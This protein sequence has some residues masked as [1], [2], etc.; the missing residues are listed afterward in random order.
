MI[1]HL[2]EKYGQNEEE[3]MSNDDEQHSSSNSEDEC[4]SCEGEEQ[5]EQSEDGWMKR[6]RQRP[7]AARL[8]SRNRESD[9]ED[10]DD[11][12]FGKG[13]NIVSPS[14]IRK[15]QSSPHPDLEKDDVADNTSADEDE[16]AAGENQGGH[17]DGDEAGNSDSEEEQVG[18]QVEAPNANT[19]MGFGRYSDETY[20]YVA[21]HYPGYVTWARLQD[22]DPPDELF[23]F[24]E[25]LNSDE[26]RSLIRWRPRQF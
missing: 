11:D 19:L 10:S 16:D 18:V 21:Q 23:E 3:S 5:E 7:T 25:W 9:N 17:G 24:V 26:G 4:T 14:S 8:K 22:D 20:G 12:F 2:K 1:R 6:K 15:T 13:S